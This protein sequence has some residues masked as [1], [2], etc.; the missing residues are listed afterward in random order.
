[1]RLKIHIDKNKNN[2]IVYIIFHII[3]LIMLFMT[4]ENINDITKIYMISPFYDTGPG[5]K[6]R[7]VEFTT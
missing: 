1:M 6:L 7:S 2:K 3:L 5:L 4:M